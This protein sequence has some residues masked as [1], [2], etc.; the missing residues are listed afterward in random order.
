RRGRSSECGASGLLISIRNTWPPLP[1]NGR[2]SKFPLSG[3]QEL[4]HRAGRA[5]CLLLADFVAKVIWRLLPELKG[6]AEVTYWSDVPPATKD[7]AA[8]RNAIV[9]HLS[10]VIGSM[11]AKQ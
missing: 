1:P 5:G 3:W 4:P 6:R 10:E 7:Y 8:A 2:T 11:T 9:K